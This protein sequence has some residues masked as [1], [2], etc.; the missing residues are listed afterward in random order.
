MARSVLHLM[1]C[2]HLGGTEQTLY[3]LMR[4]LHGRGYAFTIASMH[5]PGRGAD[6]MRDAGIPVLGHEYRGKFG[7]RTH[8]SLRRTV[9]GTDADLLLVSG[10]TLSGCLAAR[11]GRTDRRILTVHY[12]HGCDRVS[13]L[14]WGAFYRTF[15]GDY[16]R[17][18]FL[19]D[20]IRREAEAVAPRLADRFVTVR[21]PV[22]PARRIGAENRRAARDSWKLPDGVPVVVNAGQLIR[23]KRWDVFLDVAARV[24]RRNRDVHFLIAGDGPERPNLQR[25]AVE[26]GIGCRVRFVGWQTDTQA[27]YGASDVLLFNSDADAFGRTPLEAM[28]VGLPVVASVRYGGTRELIEHGRNGILLDEHDADA[29]A[30][31][32]ETLL[33]STA[34]RQRFIRAARERIRRRHGY[35]AFLRTYRELFDDVIGA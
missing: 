35:E 15:G 11:A 12:H 7:W 26:L 29:L 19:T 3:A 22:A 30:E 34:Q 23:R 1:Q 33:R 17:V 32:V 6:L 13:Q 24:A 10:P 16:A 4:G 14:R 25:R 21:A 27:V 20:F 9:A 2:T 18:T 8:R 5:P 28:A 31:H